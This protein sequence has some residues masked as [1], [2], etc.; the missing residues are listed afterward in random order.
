MS[1]KALV[2]RV[3]KE[4]LQFNNLGLLAYLFLYLGVIF[5]A[6][7]LAKMAM[8]KGD[9]KVVASLKAGGL[10]GLVIYG[11]FNFTNYA[12]F[13]NYDMTTGLKD[14]VWGGVLFF[15]TTLITLHFP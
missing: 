8:E 4:D 5:I 15:L 14:T 10:L 6:L 1:Y 7:P 11:T 3:Q 2:A 13:K 9:S 12:M